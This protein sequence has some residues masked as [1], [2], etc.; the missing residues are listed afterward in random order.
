[1]DVPAS[2]GS[3][4]PLWRA[5]AV[6]RFA[7]LGYAVLL[8][9]LN[10]GHYSRFDWA[11]VVIA[12]MTAWTAGTTV[13]YARPERRAPVLLGA[14]LVVTAG[15]LLSTFA[16]QD[17]QAIRHGVMPVTGIWV[18]GPVLAWAVRYGR[19]AGTVTALI[20]SGCDFA[21]RHEDITVVLNGV[22]LLLLAGVTIGH[23]ARLATEV[24][25]ERQHAAEIEAAS[26]E[27]ERLAR[28]IHD[29]VL[30]VLAL[31]QR[32]GAEA[33][34]EAAELG[35]LAG[36]Q[37]AALRT[38][39]VAGTRAGRG[40][41][42]ATGAPG[43][44]VDLRAL[45]LPSQAEGVVVSVPAQ[46]VRLE[47]GAAEELASAVRA[48]LDNV[49]RHGGERARAWVLVED[50]PGLVT[51]TIRDDGP[52]IP[53]GR[54]AAAAAAGRLGVS[55][56]ICG[57]LRDLG[58]SADIRSSPARAPRWSCACRGWQ[59]RRAGARARVRGVGQD[60][61]IRVMVVD[62][63]PMWR[64]AVARD[65]AEAG[66]DVVATAADGAQALRVAGAARPDVV[67]LDLQLPDMS[68]V[69]VTRG[70]R[71]AHPAAHVLVLSASGEQQDV[72][73]A[74][75]AG[76][77]GYL[78]KSAARAEFLDAVRR[79]AGGDAVF[80]PGLAALVLGEFRRLA[81]A[82]ASDEAAALQLTERETE[83]LRMVATG[84]SYKQIA[85]RLVL[86]H[87]TVQN[88]VQNTLG[89]LQLHNRVEL[90]RY[91]IEH[92]LAD[93]PQLLR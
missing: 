4:E 67:V 32:R 5:I 64:D 31:V 70:L 40:P 46:P 57:R 3:A 23:V 14:D 58:G 45:V 92:G 34:G 51:V 68:G 56:S 17:P 81:A 88:H 87:R 83:I 37:E 48:A 49:R 36:Q 63:H 30:Q 82:P 43:D 20:M 26:R 74:V 55:Q 38:L 54:L 80:T 91:A 24:E 93:E 39:L 77:V 42:A 61:P 27:R 18:A 13:A 50:E 90:V 47:M 11:W 59:W 35:R 8:A 9:I 79:T 65:L 44:D 62:D 72:L 85:T 60:A 21:L 16:L 22:V 71:A 12:V 33:G 28:G 25:A 66:Y 2:H 73:D 52:G 41:A 76:A 1:M 10:R 84:L 69:E 15:L 7:S 89:K 29:S 53:A 86:S 19:R 78:L 75:K 6:Y